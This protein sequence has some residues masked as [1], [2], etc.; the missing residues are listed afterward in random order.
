MATVFLAP[1][2]QPEQQ[3]PHSVQAGCETPAGLTLSSKLTTTGAA[4]RASPKAALAAS[5][6]RDLVNSAAFGYGDWRSIA[7][8]VA[9][10]SSSKPSL[11]TSSDQAGSANTRASGFSPTPALIRD[12][13][14]S[15]QPTST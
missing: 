3:S 4:T 5:S 10:Q 11:T 9:K 1:T 15:P 2:L 13:P 7:E 8:A 12:P 14:P 6:A